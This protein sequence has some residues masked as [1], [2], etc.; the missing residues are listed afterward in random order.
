[1]PVLICPVLSTS[2]TVAAKLLLGVLL[3]IL[4]TD[5]SLDSLIKA[6]VDPSFPIH[7]GSPT[8]IEG[9]ATVSEF[10]SQADAILGSVEGVEKE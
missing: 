3:T 2:M 8:R 6:G 5:W 9:V 7:T 10:A 4:V 1:M